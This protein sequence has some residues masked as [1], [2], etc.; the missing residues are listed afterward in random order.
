MTTEVR[1]TPHPGHEALDVRARPMLWVTAVLGLV[2]TGALAV[3]WPWRHEPQVPPAT[4]P[5]AGPA[6]LPQPIANL[7]AYRAE[8]ERELE[9]YGWVD[10]KAGITRIPI[11][12]AIEILTRQAP[13]NGEGGGQ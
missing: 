8:K 1:G 7:A 3:L 10:R 5:R 12:R 9:S 13:A 2:L 6:L 11:E 4:P